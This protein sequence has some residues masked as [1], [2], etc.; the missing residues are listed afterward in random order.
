M[1]QHQLTVRD[2]RLWHGDQALRGSLIVDA[3]G[4]WL[5]RARITRDAYDFQSDAVVETWCQGRGWEEVQ[6]VPIVDLPIVQFS[7]VTKPERWHQPMQ[8]SLRILCE[9]GLTI[10]RGAA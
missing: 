10:L 3:G 2:E 7:Y 8:E 5:F 1:T 6:R 4:T 9:L